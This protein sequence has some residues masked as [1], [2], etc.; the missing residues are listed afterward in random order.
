MVKLSEQLNEVL[1]Q[2]RIAPAVT[3]E[4]KAQPLS[5]VRMDAEASAIYS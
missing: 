3:P 4:R 2:F 5:V 1:S